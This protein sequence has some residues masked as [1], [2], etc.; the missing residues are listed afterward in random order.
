LRD[1][2][3]PATGDV[4]TDAT[5]Y[6]FCAA[7]AANEC[8]T[9]AAA[10]DAY[11]S[12]PGLSSPTCGSGANSICIGDW[13]FN[14]MNIVQW[15]FGANREG[16]VD[17]GY[18][19]GYGAG[20]SR[21]LGRGWSIRETALM[22]NVKSLSYGDWAIA[23]FPHP[24]RIDLWMVKIPTYP[25]KDSVARSTFIPVPVRLTPPAGMGVHNA[26][27]EF[28]YTPTFRCTTRDE[29][30]FANLASVNESNPFVWPSDV[31]GESSV[32]GLACGSGCTVVIPALSQRVLYYRW[33][34]RDAGGAV[35]SA[36]GM[37]VYAVQ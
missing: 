35:L 18:G 2:S 33:K 17:S 22:W 32:T 1:L 12:C 4:I 3:S 34:Y 15:G 30:C 6:T 11:V 25:P 5:P 31:G 7:N 23:Q 16:A 13:P 37:Q 27:V 10:G 26:V 14:G 36:G 24:E 28:G 21:V 20:Y 19:Q 9:G 29:A 8:R